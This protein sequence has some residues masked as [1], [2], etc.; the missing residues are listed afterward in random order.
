MHAV[1]R[2]YA[3]TD[4]ANQLAPRKDE[5]IS[6]ISEAPGF[7]AYYMIQAGN[8][9][10]S[11]TVCDDESGTQR[12]SE[13]AAGWIRENMPELASSPPEISA[14]EVAISSMG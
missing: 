3:G 10:I 6:L 11:V 1:V 14:G 12:S 9:S 2:R 7:R 5:I 13:L 8:D 4:L